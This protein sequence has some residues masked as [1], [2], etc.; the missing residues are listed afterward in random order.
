MSLKVLLRISAIISPSYFSTSP[1]MSWIRGSCWFVSLFTPLTHSQT[2]HTAHSANTRI[3]RHYAHHKHTH[4]PQVQHP[5]I[6]HSIRHHTYCIL[7]IHQAP[8]YT[9]I[10]LIFISREGGLISFCWKEGGGGWSTS[11]DA[12]THKMSVYSKIRN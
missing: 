10:H 4:I 12:Y 2:Q 3:P 7:H 8:H 5:H 11:I 6:L 9:Q 1:M